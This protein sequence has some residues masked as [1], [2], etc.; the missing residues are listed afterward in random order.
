MRK[1]GFLIILI[2]LFLSSV[3]AFAEERNIYAGDLIKLSISGKDI[4][5][6]DIREWFNEFEIVELKKKK[7]DYSIVL[8]TFETGTK[9]IDVN[10]KKIVIDVKSALEE[11]KRDGIFMGDMSPLK[12]HTSAAFQYIFYLVCFTF[13]VSGVFLLI[14]RIKKKRLTE[15]GDFEKCINKIK[16][17]STADNEYFVKLTFY[18]KEYIEKSF[19]CTIRG[20]TTTEIMAEIIHIDGLKP[21]LESIRSWLTECDYYKFTKKKADTETKEEFA[22]KLTG[23]IE[24]IERMEEEQNDNATG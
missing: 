4:S 13:I 22:N 15:P 24:T 23:L 14:K 16:S 1:A 10:N 3:S 20:K 21:C 12:S 19:L 7:D 5:E 8:R 2:I 9:T 11:I 17:L 6:N 18:L